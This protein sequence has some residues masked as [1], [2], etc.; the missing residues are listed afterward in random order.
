MSATDSS[1]FLEQIVACP[2]DDAVRLVYADWL[3]ERGESDRAELIRVQIERAALPVWDARQLPLRVRENALLKQDEWRWKQELP[4][5]KGVIW[6]TFRR[7]FVSTATLTQSSALKKHAGRLANGVPLESLS[8]GWPQARDALDKV[9]PLPGLRELTLNSMFVAG[10]EADRLAEAPMLSTVRTLNVRGCSLGIDGFARLVL[11]PHLG[12]LRALRAPFNS[13]GSNGIAA[14]LEPN[15]ITA[16]EELDLSEAESYS[17][18]NEDP[19][20]TTTGID[21]LVSWPGLKGIRSLTVAGN[22]FGRDGLRLLLHSEFTRSLKELGL[23]ENGLGGEV[24]QEFRDAPEDL[25]LTVLDLGENLIRK[26]GLE[27]LAAAR[28]LQE[29]KVLQVDRCELPESSANSLARAPFFGNLRR[30]NVNDNDLG[31]AGLR[32][33]LK[34]KSDDLHTLQIANNNLGDGA[35]EE[36]VQTPSAAS[37]QAVDLSRNNLGDRSARALKD[38]TRLERLQVLRL[39]DNPIGRVAGLSFAK[40]PIGQQLVV[41]DPIEEGETP[42][43]F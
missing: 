30:L 18:Y 4:Q 22:D 19:H 17:R 1:G 25:Q 28:C 35:I 40:S 20:L 42:V 10:S 32:A 14:L 36:L 5:L 12:Q 38:C 15:T 37:L 43:P 13:I 11:S 41:L 27:L 8:M 21:I 24:M 31:S 16:L 34:H 33:I 2:D 7:G 9:A 29:L 6:G 39:L 23:R 3:E 26:S